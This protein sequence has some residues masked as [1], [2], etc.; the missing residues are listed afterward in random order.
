[1]RE[2]ERTA[3]GR[4]RRSHTRGR[5]VCRVAL[6][7]CLLS[8]LTII[9]LLDEHDLRVG[10]ARLKPAGSER[11]TATVVRPRSLPRES[12][13]SVR[14]ADG[15]WRTSDESRSKLIDAGPNFH[16][17]TI[18]NETAQRKVLSR[19]PMEFTTAAQQTQVVMTLPMPDG[20]FSR[21]G[22]EESPVM[23]PEL[24]TRFPQIKTYRGRGLDDPTTTAR[25]DVTPQGFHA[26][27]LTSAGTVIVE[28]A[29]HASR[30]E[31]L[32]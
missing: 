27:V 30:S 24:A 8:G 9:G 32:S 28:P 16:S 3:F 6:V 25:M 29:Q 14:S 18:L 22:V 2:V 26:I 19:A 31:Y 4:A 12:L 10:A 7:L 13:K 5:F 15:L 11:S 21:F 23:A 17:R 20:T 1:M